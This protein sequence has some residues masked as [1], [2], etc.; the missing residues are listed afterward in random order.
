MGIG[1]KRLGKVTKDL[2]KDQKWSLKTVVST[3]NPN[4]Y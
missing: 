3:G 2:R 1:N 4:S